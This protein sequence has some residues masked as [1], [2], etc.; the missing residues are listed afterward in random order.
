MIYFNSQL[1]DQVHR[2][3]YE[4]LAPEGILIVGA[5]ESISF[6]PMS[7]KYE[8]FNDRNRIFRKIR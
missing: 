5:K 2:L 6:T 4:S 3:F 1:R 7:E 8:I